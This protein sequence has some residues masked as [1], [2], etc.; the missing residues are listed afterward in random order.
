[1]SSPWH[2]RYRRSLNVLPFLRLNETLHGISWTVHIGPFSY[3]TRTHRQTVRTPVPGL[4]V[5]RRGGR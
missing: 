4:S 5:W 3:N 1:M 2:I